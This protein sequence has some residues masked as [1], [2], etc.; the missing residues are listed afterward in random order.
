MNALVNHKWNEKNHKQQ[1]QKYI[2]IEEHEAALETNRI[3]CVSEGIA[4][5]QR[6]AILAL[7]ELGWRKIRMT[8][9]IQAFNAEID[10][11]AMMIN[12]EAKEERGNKS[13]KEWKK[14]KFDFAYYETKTKERLS[15]LI[16]GE[17]D[18]HEKRN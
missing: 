14:Q 8:R 10:N 18:P 17:E 2:P 11:Y 4:L 9:F 1:P 3:Q 7:G 6:F 15:L 12:Q 16:P 5:G 13:Y